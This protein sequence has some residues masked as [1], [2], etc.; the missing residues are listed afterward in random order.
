MIRQRLS[1]IFAAIGA[2]ATFGLLSSGMLVHY[3]VLPLEGAT[4]LILIVSF[5]LVAPV[6]L[7]ISVV[8]ASPIKGE[9]LVRI[10]AEM[11]HVI[12]LIG[13][14]INLLMMMGNTPSDASWWR[15]IIFGILTGVSTVVLLALIARKN[16]RA[17]GKKSKNQ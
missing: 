16:K 9:R 11:A 3:R 13:F 7:V 8:L 15:V 2:L 6:G 10:L 17:P 14:V 5:A 4:T 1:I 12:F